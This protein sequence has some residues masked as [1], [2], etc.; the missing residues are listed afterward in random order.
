MIKVISVILIFIKPPLPLK[1]QG[2]CQ[3]R[4][5]NTLKG[6]IKIDHVLDSVKLFDRQKS[7]PDELALD[8][9][10]SLNYRF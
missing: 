1:V 8:R 5:S 7:N 4:R 2:E 10:F 9:V 3:K 6:I